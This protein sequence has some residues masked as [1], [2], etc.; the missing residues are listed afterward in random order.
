MTG[1]SSES[2]QG[3]IH[4][5]AMPNHARASGRRKKN[6][7]KADCYFCVKE[8]FIIAV[9]YNYR[10]SINIGYHFSTCWAG[11]GLRAPEKARMG[12]DRPHPSVDKPH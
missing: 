6:L 2:F 3:A 5:R 9:F 8:S 4:R 1:F 12:P 7:M 11:V 10:S